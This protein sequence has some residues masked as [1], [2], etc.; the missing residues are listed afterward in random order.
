M[1][2]RNRIQR[3]AHWINILDEVISKMNP[4]WH[5][6]LGFWGKKSNQTGLHTAH[7]MCKRKVL[8]LV[9]KCF[10]DH[11]SIRLFFDVNVSRCTEWLPQNSDRTQIYFKY[12]NWIARVQNW[13][14]ILRWYCNQLNVKL[15]SRWAH[16]KYSSFF[17][18]FINDLLAYAE[19]S[20]QRM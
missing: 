5:F 20:V 14:H 19:K 1:S 2:T 9:R 13:Y 11:G 12:N 18:F 8:L 17:F 10:L 3:I 6:H 16:M 7:H 15:Q 4:I